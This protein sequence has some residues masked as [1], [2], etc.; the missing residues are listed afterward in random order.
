MIRKY[1]LR[2]LPTAL[3]N[4]N[5]IMLFLPNNFL[6]FQKYPGQLL[7]QAFKKLDGM[8]NIKQKVV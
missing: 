4:I 6:K 7:P 8:E 2:C 5:S 1:P 3:L